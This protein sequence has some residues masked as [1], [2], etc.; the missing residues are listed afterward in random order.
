MLK[1]LIKNAIVVQADKL[2]ENHA[3]LCSGGRIV[4]IAPAGEL[5]SA[6]AE[7]VID[8]QGGYLAAGY[9]DLHI[10]GLQR[11]IIDN[12]PE[13]L[14]EICGLLPQYGVTGFLPSVTP[15]P[16]GKDAAFLASLAK[17]KSK[18]AQ[19][20][21]FHLEGPFLTLTG[22]LRP[23]AIGKAD[24]DRVRAL[25]EAAK[26]YRA[27]FSI[28]PDFE[29]ISELI[30]IM[31]ANHTPVFMTHTKANVK[32]T[33]AAIEAGVLH[34]THFYD[35]FPS[36]EESDAGVR[37]CGVV[38][39]VL[40]EP[41]VSVD[42]ILDGEHVEPVAVKMALQCKGAGGVCLITDS[43]IGA[44][45][46][47]GRYS[48]FGDEEIEF[49]YAG[50]PARLTENSHFPGALA[51]SGLTMDR[52]VRNA[53]KMLGVDLPQAVRMVSA[54]PARVLGLDGNKGQ[55]KEGYDADMVL[56][57]ESLAVMRT[58]IGGEC[59]FEKKQ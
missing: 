8:A 4:K 1:V 34:A 47:P 48:G 38:E 7:K 16:K 43:N 55:I 31:A 14:A 46:A 15:K 10:H 33:Q 22:A 44:G 20:L 45:L 58:W 29:G 17:V 32:Q 27:I 30:G 42:F 49:S 39:A 5:D 36:P 21:G 40:A 41:R 59:C 57:D 53:I 50:G 23:E 11:S 26:P 9:I 3:V 56:L 24:S 19:I 13:D 37:P 12:G 51:G 6:G 2:L 52:V 35:V 25:I 28:A 18:G 54:N